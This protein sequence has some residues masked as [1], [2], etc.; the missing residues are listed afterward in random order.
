MTTRLRSRTIRWWRAG[1]CSWS[2]FSSTHSCCSYSWSF[3]TCTCGWLRIYTSKLTP[4]PTPENPETLLFFFFRENP[5]QN[6]SQFAFSTSVRY[7]V[8]ILDSFLTFPEPITKITSSSCFQ[9]RRLI[10]IRR[11]VSTS[12]MT[13]IVHAFVFSTINYCNSFLISLPKIGLYSIQPVL[14]VAFRL[15]SRLTKLVTTPLASNDVCPTPYHRQR[16]L[17]IVVRAT[18]SIRLT[19]MKPRTIKTNNAYKTKIHKNLFLYCCLKL[20]A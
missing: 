12:T 14:N 3:I 19:R 8:A 1:L 17:R 4:P 18:L 10:A 6:F 9:L 5:A 2:S 11:S 20:E 15:I 13:S 7:L 16:E